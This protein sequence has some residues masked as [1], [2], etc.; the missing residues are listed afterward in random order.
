MHL[1]CMIVRAWSVITRRAP[2]TNKT[3]HDCNIRIQGC[4]VGAYA[5]WYL[6]VFVVTTYSSSGNETAA[7]LLVIRIEI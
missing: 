6:Y 1:V 5:R 7:V 4:R 2:T 3:H